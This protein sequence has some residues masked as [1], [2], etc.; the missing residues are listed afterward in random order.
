MAEEDAVQLYRA[1]ANATTDER[2]KKLLNDIADEEVV[3]IGEFQKLIDVLT[4]SKEKELQL[5]GEEEA[6]DKMNKEEFPK[7]ENK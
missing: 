1:H 4:Q 6:I 2:A 7:P 5:Q 3:H